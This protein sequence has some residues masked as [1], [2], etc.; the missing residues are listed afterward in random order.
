MC[1]E[2]SKFRR[3]ETAENILSNCRA[4][5]KQLYYFTFSATIALF[6]FV[7]SNNFE[8]LCFVELEDARS[9][10]IREKAF[11]V[12]KFTALV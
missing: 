3:F 12:L 5:L 8:S 1:V 2:H 10:Q 4:K 6:C 11:S 9:V 7:Q